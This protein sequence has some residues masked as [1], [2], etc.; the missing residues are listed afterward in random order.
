MAGPLHFESHPV[1]RF[2]AR[3]AVAAAGLLLATFALAQQLAPQEDRNVFPLDGAAQWAMDQQGRWTAAEV[4]RND[5]IAWQLSPKGG[6]HRLT[7]G[8]ALWF[9]FTVPPLH[10]EGWLLQI[11]YPSVNLAT[12]FEVTAEGAAEV[13]HAGDTVPVA[14]WP[15]PHRYPLLPVAVSPDAP[16]SYLLKIENPH[17]FSARM[18][19]VHR[20]LTGIREQRTTL[21][22]GIY[23]GL[24]GLA[25]L[26]AA[27]SGVVLHDMTYVRYFVAVT[28][29]ALA[30]AAATGV[31]GLLLW[32][33]SPWWNDVSPLLL[34]VLAG[35]AFLWFI[36]SAVSLADRH[37]GLNW[38]V[39]GLCVAGIATAIGVALV[40]PSWRFRLQVPAVAV[41]CVAGAAILVW[42]AR[43]GDRHARWMLYALLP[44]ALTAM[45][46][47]AGTAGLIPVSALTVNS[48]PIAIALELPTLLGILLL[49]NQDRREHGRRLLGLYHTDP[50]TG[51]PNARVFETRLQEMVARARRM[52]YASVLLLVDLEDEAQA[53][54]NFGAT[55]HHQLALH[56]AGRLLS[57]ARDPDTVA[58]LGDT[59]FG[60]LVEGPLTADE[61]AGMGQRVVARCLMPVQN[62]PVA[63]VLPVRVAQA[64]V[65]RDGT[66]AQELLAALRGLLALHGGRA[67]QPLKRAAG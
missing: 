7:T 30:Q 24:A 10:G 64:I 63:Q 51:L 12:L 4:A 27:I 22:L 23:F 25:A 34:P 43:R 16:R 1:L 38:L 60:M 39:L 45:L 37:K 33:H 59:R 35:T 56:L 21:L 52:G 15:V 2:L 9:R 31:G 50:A 28:A 32:P 49:R 14:Q 54:V 13:A 26:V 48:M 11:E 53:R 41:A 5:A 47:L 19:L 58:R 8:Q 65:P 36:A 17:T 18:E 61:A 40:E 44:V 3:L 42:A 62:R 29:M 20:Q 6:I 67:V 57:I 55:Q 66:D 46:P